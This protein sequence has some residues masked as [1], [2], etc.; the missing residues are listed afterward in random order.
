MKVLVNTSYGR[1]FSFLA[2][3]SL[4]FHAFLMGSTYNIPPSQRSA[5]Q[6]VIPTDQLPKDITTLEEYARAY[7]QDRSDIPK[8]ELV[9][10]K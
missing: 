5:L 3:V 1:L 2:V 9:T 8:P 7:L 4:P 10:A 6:F